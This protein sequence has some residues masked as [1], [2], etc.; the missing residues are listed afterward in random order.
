MKTRVDECRIEVDGVRLTGTLLRP[1]AFIPGV[2]FVHGWGGSQAQDLARARAAAGLGCACLTFDL[3][4]DA[5]DIG[6]SGTVTREENLRDLVAAY[7]HLAGMRGVDPAGIAVVGT[8]Y[9]GYLATLLTELREVRWLAL[10]A[11]AIYKDENWDKPKKSL[12][13]DPD[14]MRYRRS[15]L[16]AG[17]GNRALRA[18]AAFRGD[19][20]LVESEHDDF[21]PHAVALNYVASFTHAQSITSR[22]IRGADHA[23]TGA[24][25]QEAYSKLLTGW[26]TEMVVGARAAL[27]DTRH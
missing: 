9:G 21:V 8:S 2:L 17:E 11:P 19:V 25:A 18:C 27:A 16:P 23:L 15:R 20:L 24:E 14:L 3:R 5:R 4:G 26:I 10:Q 22:M 1:A 12:N 13:A 6:R 7:D